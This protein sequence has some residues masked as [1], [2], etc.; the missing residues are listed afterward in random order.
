[1]KEKRQPDSRKWNQ[2]L[3]LNRRYVS[4][5]IYAFFTFV[6]CALFYQLVAN[7][8]QV[9]GTLVTLW[10]LLLPF[11]MGGVVA[12]I[13]NFT[14]RFLEEK[15]FDRMKK[16][17]SRKVKRAFSLLL[18][19]LIWLALLTV[20][21]VIVIPQ[22]G[23]SL[24]SIASRTNQ[25][26]TTVMSWV[27]Q[28]VEY[29]RNYSFTQGQIDFVMEKLNELSDAMFGLL[30]QSLPY[31][32]NLTMSVTVGVKNL[33]LGIII[34]IYLLA[35]KEVFFAQLRKI[36]YAFFAKDTV[37]GLEN[38]AR[39]S[40]RIFSG[41]FMGKLLD[42]LII[43][44]LC[45]IGMTLI[46]LPY[47][48]LISVIVGVTNVIPYF[49]P[50]IGAIPSALLILMVDPMQ[51]LWFV[52]FILALQQFDG[53]IL[54]PKILGDSTGLPAFWVIFSILLF[55]GLFGF[56]GMFIGVPTFSVLYMLIKRGL[57]KRLLHLRYPVA[58]WEYENGAPIHRATVPEPDG[59][60]GGEP[61]SQQP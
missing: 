20:F 15:F 54:G 19:Y 34:S 21:F 60:E 11:V 52:L 27:N 47:A 26:T 45:F 55:G 41:F 9:R 17:L 57:T 5:S 29:M 43:G 1:M 6:A 7:F 36:C 24:A 10:N 31:L 3:P 42:S 51:C 50:F 28:L 2:K 61:D 16:P 12:Y 44:I 38:L 14:M 46:G 39:E 58:T 25:Y 33:I 8:S 18:T 40:N 53:N 37:I 59:E 49:G 56:V 32:V 4:V 35:G 22:I 48:M 23:V 13:L 30:N